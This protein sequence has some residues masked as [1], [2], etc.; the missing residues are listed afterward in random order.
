MRRRDAQVRFLNINRRISALACG[1]LSA[2]LERDLLLVGAQTTLL[3]YDVVENADVFFKDAPDGVNTVVVGKFGE[4]LT[5]MALV[6]GNCSIQGFDASGSE[7]FWTVTGDNVSTMT[8]CDVDED[9]ELE[10]LVGSDDFE[11]RVFHNDE[12]RAATAAAAA[13][14][15]GQRSL[16]AHGCRA[17]IHRLSARHASIVWPCRMRVRASF[18]WAR[19]SSRRP[20]KPIASSPSVR[21]GGTRLGTLSPT[22]RSAYTRARGS[23]GGASR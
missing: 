23:G 7:A 19:R 13:R 2:K 14:V 15:Q 16:S 12:V 5:P 4:A 20:L 6:G 17:S 1:Q 9:G 10:L 22:A 3:A 18:V 8:F 21:C 11:I